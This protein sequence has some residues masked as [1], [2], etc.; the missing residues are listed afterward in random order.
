ML[1]FRLRVLSVDTDNKPGK[2][3]LG[4][5]LIID[6]PEGKQSLKVDLIPY[7]INVPQEGFF[8]VV[9]HIFIEE[10]KFS[11]YE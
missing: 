6:K 2:D 1:T 3:L 5:D 8:V 10:N 4:A 7:K 11:T 9:E